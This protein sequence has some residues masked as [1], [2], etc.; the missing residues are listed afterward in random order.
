MTSK[1][2]IKDA[3]ITQLSNTPEHTIIAAIKTQITANLALPEIQ[4]EII[5][6]FDTP[7]TKEEQEIINLC[8]LAEF[9][10]DTNNIGENSL[11]ITMKQFL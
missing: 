7:K 4:N 3:F 10:F 9:G 2:G 1:Q 5:Y 6:T 8:M 11:T